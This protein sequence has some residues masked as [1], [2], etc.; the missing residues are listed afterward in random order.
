MSSI[1]LFSKGERKFETR[2]IFVTSRDHLNLIS[3]TG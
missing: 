1:S 3:D 2:M